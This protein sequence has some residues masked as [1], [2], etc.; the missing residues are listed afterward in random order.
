M[1]AISSADNLYIETRGE[2]I[3][4]GSVNLGE[5]VDAPQDSK[6]D[7]SPVRVG[8]IGDLGYQVGRSRFG[9]NA[10]FGSGGLNLDRVE[11][12]YLG[13][14]TLAVGNTSYVSGGVGAQYLLYQETKWSVPIG[15]RLGLARLSAASPAGV[16]ELDTLYAELGVGLSYQFADAHSLTL[17]ALAQTNRAISVLLEEG[18]RQ[19]PL[20]PAWFRQAGFSVVYRLKL[21]V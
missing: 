1:V 16:A 21:G 15:V 11:S 17:G 5:L 6:N 7:L 20:E 8:F 12:I 19:R 9:V 14:P 3:A 13:S 10:G 4:G 18:S 2:L